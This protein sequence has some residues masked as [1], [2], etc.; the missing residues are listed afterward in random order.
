WSAR[1]GARSRVADTRA[2]PGG[3]A[4]SQDASAQAEVE[5]RLG[6]DTSFDVAS[7]DGV[8]QV[9]I[10]PGSAP[11]GAPAGDSSREAKARGIE[12]IGEIELFAR[13]SAESAET[14]EYRPRVSAVTGTNGKTTVTAST[15]DSLEA[16]GS[17][18]SAAGNIS[19][20][21]STAS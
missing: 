7:S 6:C 5:Y 1:Q 17:S 18:V 9:V 21:A 10:S 8:D 2:E 14:R 12:V 11:E 13:A 19:P 20:A 4:A 3:S 15:R 16:S